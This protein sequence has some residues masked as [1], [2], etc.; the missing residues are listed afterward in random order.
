MELHERD[1]SVCVTEGRPEDAFVLLRAV[2]L[3]GSIAVKPE[4]H[5][6]EALFSQRIVGER[7]R[8][9]L[10]FISLP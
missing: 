7:V 9:V 4:L 1:D 6:S 3:V 8:C 10:R 5:G 2:S